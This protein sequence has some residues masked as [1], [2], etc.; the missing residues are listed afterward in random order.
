MVSFL[1]LIIDY[2]Y[3]KTWTKFLQEIIL[4]VCGFGGVAQ[5]GS[6]VAQAVI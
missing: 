1:F 2:F 5:T 3:E 4:C 6:H